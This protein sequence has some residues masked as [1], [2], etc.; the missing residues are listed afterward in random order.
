MTRKEVTVIEVLDDNGSLTLVEFIA[1][2]H[3]ERER[4]VE[5]VDV[6]LLEPTGQLIDQWRFANRDLRRVRAAQRLINDL[7]INP[8]AAALILDLIEERDE[9]LARAAMLE[10]MLEE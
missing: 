3:L 8:S 6:G 2:T 7:G 9:L 5:F 10:R 4:L 1:T